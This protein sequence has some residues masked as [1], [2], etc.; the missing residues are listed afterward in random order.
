MTDVTPE[1]PAT[2]LA[3]IMCD[4]LAGN[5][6][7]AESRRRTAAVPLPT[8]PKPSSLEPGG[9]QLGQDDSARAARRPRGEGRTF[10]RGGVLWIAY[11]HRGKE[12]R[13]SA[14]TTDQRK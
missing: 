6:S 1:N 7:P 4:T 12:I 14:K 5:I 3:E 10:P 8:P 9:D 11:Y 2:T 13:E